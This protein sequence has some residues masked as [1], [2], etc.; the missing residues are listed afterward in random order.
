MSIRV[1]VALA[2][3]LTLAQGRALGQSLADVARQEE[4]RRKNITTPSKVLTNEDLRHAGVP[5]PPSGSEQ[6]PAQTQPST[7][8]GGAS[9]PPATAPQEPAKDQAY[10][11]G[12]ITEARDQLDRTKTFMEAVQNRINSLTTDYVNRDDPAQRA[13]LERERQKNVAELERLKKEIQQ[14]TKAIAD[15]EEEARRAGVPPGW[16]R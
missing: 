15:I 14:Q 12:R 9:T 4:A 5:E 2:V 13:V 8:P 6:K 10:W 1:L 7:L 11:R 3:S 16:L